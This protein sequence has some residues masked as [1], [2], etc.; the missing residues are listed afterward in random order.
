MP[1]DPVEAGRKGGRSRSARKLAAIRKNGFQKVKPAQEPG[2]EQ[3]VVFA[4][5]QIQPAKGILL[6]AQPKQEQK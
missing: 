5:P 2:T 4:C 1:A 3:P 6:T